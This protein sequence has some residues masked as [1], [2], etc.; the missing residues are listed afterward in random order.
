MSVS[1]Q[2]NWLLS[3][4]VMSRIFAFSDVVL[5]NLWDRRWRD[6]LSTCHSKSVGLSL[7]RFYAICEKYKSAR[8]TMALEDNQNH[9]QMLTNQPFAFILS[10]V[11]IQKGCQLLSVKWLAGVG[12]HLQHDL[13]YP[14]FCVKWDVLQP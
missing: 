2:L 11:G 1:L 8:W 7:Q 6:K 13:S 12:E 14:V 10:S 4:V 9:R 5:V 3:V